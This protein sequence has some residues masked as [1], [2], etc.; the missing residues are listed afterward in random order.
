MQ[1]YNRIIEQ[2]FSNLCIYMLMFYSFVKENLDRSP[3]STESK[4][5]LLT[6]S[7]SCK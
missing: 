5:Y 7:N 3:L 6:T 2:M 4:A 1:I